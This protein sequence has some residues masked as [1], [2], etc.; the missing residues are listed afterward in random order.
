[1]TKSEIEHSVN[2]SGNYYK[3][4]SVLA[5]LNHNKNRKIGTV[6]AESKDKLIIVDNMIKREH[7]YLIPKTKVDHYN[8]KRM[9]FDLS[10]NSLR[11][12]EM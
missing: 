10:E 9:Y 2:L 7:V 11:D 1:M 6:I 4:Y 8:D 5:L 12:Y 3:F